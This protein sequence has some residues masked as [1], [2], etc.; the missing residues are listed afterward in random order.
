M[1]NGKTNRI[2][3][4]VRA[5]M[6]VCFLCHLFF[7]PQNSGNLDVLFFKNR[8]GKWFS[9][10][11]ELF[12]FY[13]IVW[14]SI[15]GVN[16][17][18][19]IEHILSTRARAIPYALWRSQF[20]KLKMNTFVKCIRLHKHLSPCALCRKVVRDRVDWLWFINQGARFFSS[21]YPIPI[22]TFTKKIVRCKKKLFSVKD[23]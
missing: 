15:K 22:S 4:S 6:R 1:I 20:K 9:V 18:I 5:C 16:F 17:I 19:K 3:S 14:K 11:L 12:V 10:E 13:L 21:F 2:N 8:V 7:C 23:I